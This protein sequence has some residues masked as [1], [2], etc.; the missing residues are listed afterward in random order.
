[1]E[2]V[3]NFCGLQPKGPSAIMTWFP[4][5]A[6]SHM[7]RSPKTTEVTIFSWIFA[8]ATASRKLFLRLLAA[9]GDPF[10]TALADFKTFSTN[11]I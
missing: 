5:A 9:F 2:T 10:K 4:K 11:R 7:N 3:A 6:S 1:M 8:I